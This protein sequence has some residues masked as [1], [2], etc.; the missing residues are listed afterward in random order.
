MSINSESKTLINITA[1][2]PLVHEGIWRK[3]A[4]GVI[5]QNDFVLYSDNELSHGGRP[6]DMIWQSGTVIH[7]ATRYHFA[8]SGLAFKLAM[9]HA[10][11]DPEMLAQLLRLPKGLDI[12]KQTGRVY[13]IASNFMGLDPI[14]LRKR[15][16]PK[17]SK[18]IRTAI[19]VRDHKTGREEIV[20]VVNGNAFDAQEIAIKRLYGDV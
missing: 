7:I 4:R 16:L 14:V 10:F 9:E 18:S 1:K 20:E 6:V 17:F 19:V 13:Q 12:T 5:A 8:D 2:Y 3:Y 11:K 15:E